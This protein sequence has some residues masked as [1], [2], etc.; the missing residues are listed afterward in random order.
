[1]GKIRVSLEFNCPQGVYNAGG[2]LQGSVVLSLAEP[3]KIT[4]KLPMISNHLH[5]K[6][7]TMYTG[8]LAFVLI[9][10]QSGLYFFY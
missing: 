1:M 3:S 4:S 2:T 6:W 8:T 9:L 5:L 7:L 10:L